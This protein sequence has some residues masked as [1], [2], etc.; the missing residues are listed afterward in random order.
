MEGGVVVSE[1]STL[2]SFISVVGVGGCGV[3]LLLMAISLG[4]VELPSSEIDNKFPGPVRSFIPAYSK[5][6]RYIQTHR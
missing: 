1:P 4:R 2:N 5:I 3:S 6:F